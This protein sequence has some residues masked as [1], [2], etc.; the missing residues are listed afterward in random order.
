M[1]HDEGRE[2][3]SKGFVRVRK[4]AYSIIVSRDLYFHAYLT[5]RSLGNPSAPYY[6]SP[7]QYSFKFPG[8]KSINKYRKRNKA[9]MSYVD[10]ATSPTSPIDGCLE[11]L[12]VDAPVAQQPSLGG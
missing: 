9:R 12:Q 2:W 11:Q 7:S 4:K 6:P 3:K 1:M 10:A 5:S 8:H